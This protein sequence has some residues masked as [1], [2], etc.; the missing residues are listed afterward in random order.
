[1]HL[2][3]SNL[4]LSHQNP[5]AEKP[6][7]LPVHVICNTSDEQIFSNISINSRRPGAWVK[8]VSAHA[9]VAVLCG[10][11]PSLADTLDDIRQHRANGATIFAMNGAA[12]FLH[13]HGLT[14]DY[15]AIIDAREETAQLVGPARAHLFAS[16][17]HPACFERQPFAQVWHLQVTNI[18][19]YLPDYDEG[20]CLIGGAASV[21][22]TVTC[23][24]YALGF[25]EMH[26]YGYDSSHRD[27]QGH[28]FRQALNDGDPCASVRFCGKDYIAS[29]TMKLQAEKFMETSR[30]LTQLGCSVQVHGTGLLPDMYNT[31]REA[32]TEQQKYERMWTIKEYR[33]EA[34]GERLV[35]EFVQAFPERGRVLD[36]GCGTGRASVRLKALGYD[37]TLLD[38][39]D[40]SRDY[41]ALVLPF[42]RHD[43]TEP[44][45]VTGQ[46]GFC[47]DLMEHV[48][49]ES[50]PTVLRHI[51]NAT[52]QAFFQ[53][54]TEP[55]LLGALINQ[56]LHLTVQPAAWWREQ[57]TLAGFTILD[58]TIH[59][60][61]VLFVTAAH[62]RE[63]AVCQVH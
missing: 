35:N 50:V 53:I 21:G 23:L 49:P 38:F 43:V 58:E 2:P 26:C 9:G 63:E 48:P 16:Q 61:A 15:Q 60:Q 18:D 7:I 37:V 10:S 20:Y 47:T 55:D 19:D 54:S 6:L 14:A 62:I 27:G 8:P 46:Y 1:M 51:R 42:V 36:I 59:S 5:G 41:E 28:A 29:L 13:Q 32:L 44:F 3:Y 33:K 40:N 30:N 24:A 25:R 34:P 17:V 22:N 12:A 31:P 57:L 4:Q 52:Q 45:P 11:G 39:T 56:P